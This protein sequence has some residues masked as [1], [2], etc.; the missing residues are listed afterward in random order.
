MA[1]ARII[2]WVTE[3]FL[4]AI[5]KDAAKDAAQDATKDAEHKLEQDLFAFGGK[6]DDGFPRPPRDSDLHVS[7]PDEP[8]GPY[9]PHAP[10]DEVPGAS[11][12]TSVQAGQDQGLS[13]Q[14]FR[15]PEGTD[16]PPGYGVHA[17]GADV[18][19][20]APPGHRTIYPSQ[21]MPVSDFQQGYGSPD[22]GWEWHGT[23]NKKGVFTPAPKP[24][25]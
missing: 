16:L 3:L 5:G 12:Y 1:G 24:E 11:T 20:T 17:D 8:V 10:T 18:G 2:E 15:L 6:R 19:G 14:V 7:S 23:V 22:F 9:S 13:G 25:G 21:R 4:K